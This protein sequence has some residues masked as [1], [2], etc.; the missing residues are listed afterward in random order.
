MSAG[1]ATAVAAATSQLGVPYV[2]FA[3]QPGIAFD[4]SGLTAWA[5]AQ[6]GVKL[7]HQSGMQFASMPHVAVADAQP[8]DLLFYHSPISHVT[9]YIGNGR[10]IHA[11]NPGSVVQIGT[12]NWANVVGIGRPG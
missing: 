2:A 5:W 11:P 7:P 10:M 12:V 4:C 9:I 3:L 8:G 1:A 6:A